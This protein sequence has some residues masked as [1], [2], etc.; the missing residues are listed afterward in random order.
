[1]KGHM[2]AERGMTLVEILVATALFSIVM[3]TAVGAVISI[4]DSNKKA[5]LSR[6]VM[7]NLNFAMENMARNLRMGTV[8]HCGATGSYTVPADCP[9]GANAIAFEGYRGS[10]GNSDD[11]IVFRLSGGRIER[12]LTSGSPGSYL[13]ITSAELTIDSL[14]FYVTNTAAGDAKQPRIT[15]VVSGS[16]SFK[17]TV[18]AFKI[19]TGVSQRRLDS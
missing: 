8:Y 11:Q 19:Q 10:A 15:I 12:S 14:M 9:A 6:T 16:A 4:N 2:R 13:P 1:M 3:L 5:Q 7:D 18:T 17:G